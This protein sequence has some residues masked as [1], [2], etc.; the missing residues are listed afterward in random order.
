M[1]FFF[2]K[3]CSTESFKGVNKKKE[4]KNGKYQYRHDFLITFNN[5]KKL[6]I[7]LDGIQHYEQVSNWKGPFEQQI[8][9]KYKE[10]KARKHKI[11]LIRCKQE[12]VLMDRN[13]WKKKLKKNLKKY[14]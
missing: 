4:L 8:R 13:N 12:D 6:I 11:P 10:F 3:I 14:N 2:E 1:K 9:D 7:E 5:K